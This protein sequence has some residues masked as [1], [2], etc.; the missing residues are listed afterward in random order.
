MFQILAVIQS[1]AFMRRARRRH[2]SKLQ[3]A[4]TP[5][6]QKEA[7][8]AEKVQNYSLSPLTQGRPGLNPAS[9]AGLWGLGRS[10]GARAHPGR[11]RAPGSIFDWTTQDRFNLV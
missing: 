7:R 6:H 8:P 4:S 3:Q 10:L 11:E 5:R 2:S 1:V 9:W